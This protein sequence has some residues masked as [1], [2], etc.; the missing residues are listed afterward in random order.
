M[1]VIYGLI[2]G[3]GTI[4]RLKKNATN[5]W[6]LS[7]EEPIPWSDVMGSGPI[8]TWLLPVD[9]YFPDYDRVMGYAT[10]QRLLREQNMEVAKRRVALASLAEL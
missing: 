5:T 10:M 7:D 3:V 1:S 9:P 4:D 8:W 2:T 6:H